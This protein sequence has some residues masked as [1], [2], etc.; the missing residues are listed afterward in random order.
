MNVFASKSWLV[1]DSELMFSGRPNANINSELCDKADKCSSKM[2]FL[3]QTK[4]TW[5][6]RDAAFPCPSLNLEKAASR[7]G[8]A[9][10]FSLWFNKAVAHN[11]YYP[12]HTTNQSTFAC[13]L[14]TYSFAVY[15]QCNPDTWYHLD[16]QEM[17]RQRFWC[18]LP[19]HHSSWL[20]TALRK[21]T[22]NAAKLLVLQYL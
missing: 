2:V 13:V 12:A 11:K 20:T 10:C 15:C 21:Q 5:S 22:N 18:P 16:K 6:S 7:R 3:R 17:P 8:L 4:S 14:C 1:F 19:S 9:A